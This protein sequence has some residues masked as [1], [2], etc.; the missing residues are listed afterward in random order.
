M[1]YIYVYM[2]ICTYLCMSVNDCMYDVYIC[3]YKYM[4]VCLRLYVLCG[5]IYIYI[6]IKVKFTLEQA[7]KARRVVEA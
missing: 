7:T 2:Y 4:Y 5:Y 1:Y 6:Y 3:L